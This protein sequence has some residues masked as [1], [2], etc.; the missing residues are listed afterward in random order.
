MENL[1][2]ERARVVRR[3][4]RDIDADSPKKSTAARVGS[5]FRHEP[6]REVLVGCR[7]EDLPLGQ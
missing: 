5:G 2:S 6:G 3:W 1:K 7:V 4:R